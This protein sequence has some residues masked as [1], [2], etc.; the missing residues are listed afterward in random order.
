[1]LKNW[2][3]GREGQT[4]VESGLTNLDEKCIGKHIFRTAVFLQDAP[5][6]S[7]YDKEW[8]TWDLKDSLVIESHKCAICNIAKKN[9]PTPCPLFPYLRNF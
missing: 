9:S 6:W 3:I 2:K 1:M 5:E 7:I 4:L 8:M